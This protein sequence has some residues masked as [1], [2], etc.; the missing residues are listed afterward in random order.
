MKTVMLLAIC[1]A[2]ATACPATAGETIEPFNGQDLSGW[3]VKGNPSKSK[4]TV[5]TATRGQ[6]NMSGVMLGDRSALSCSTASVGDQCQ[7][8][9]TEQHERGRFGNVRG[10]HLSDFAG[11]VAEVGVVGEV[12][13][14]SRV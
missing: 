2:A 4:W 1:L 13:E 14:D 12:V 3:H 7:G 10:H 11:V 5:G 9:G 6:T 8:T